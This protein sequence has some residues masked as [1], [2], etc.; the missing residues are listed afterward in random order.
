MLL[1]GYGLDEET[2]R[3]YWIVKNSWSEVWGEAGFFNLYMKSAKGETY[4]WGA[5]SIR[6]QSTLAHASLSDGIGN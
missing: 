4:P 1:V 2:G 5:C 6:T 3:E